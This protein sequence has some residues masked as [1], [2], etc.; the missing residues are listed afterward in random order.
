MNPAILVTISSNGQ[1]TVTAH[2]D[3]AEATKHGEAWQLTND[4]N[5][6]WMAREQK[7]QTNT[8]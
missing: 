3:L 5:P 6:S 7:N 2:A 8:L 1:V 4:D